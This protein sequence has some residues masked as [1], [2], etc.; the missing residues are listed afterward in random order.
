[1]EI[2]SKIEI[3]D[4]TF[5]KIIDEE[6]IH[7]KIEIIADQINKDYYQKK[8]LFL[9]VLNGA[10]IFATELFKKIK[11]DCEIDFLKIKSYEKTASKNIN[12]I[13]FPDNLEDKN[14]ILVEDI[15]DTGKTINHIK[16]KI[17]CKSLRIATLFSKPEIHDLDVNY[18]GFELKNKFIV[19]YGLDY[20]E[21]GRN[22]TSIFC[23]A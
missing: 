11:L 22:L 18:V 14:I 3:L 2:N 19:G 8:V 6:T 23:E 9:C 15:I 16:N 1:M 12:E 7:K 13:M 20:E 4:K 21:K 17:K 10:F 5:V